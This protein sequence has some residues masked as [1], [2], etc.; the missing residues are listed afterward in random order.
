MSELLIPVRVDLGDSPNKLKIVEGSLRGMA[1]G[2]DEFASSAKKASDGLKQGFTGDAT[3]TIKQQFREANIELQNLVAKFGALSPQAQAAAA[4]VANLRDVIEDS[5]RAAQSA[6]FEDR[7]RTGAQAIGGVTSAFQI[8]LSVQGLFGEQSKATEEALKKV[9]AAMALTQGI[10]GLT[11]GYKAFQA[12]GASASAALKGIKTGIAATGIGVLLLAVGALVAYWDN[13]KMA[14]SGVS[15]ETKKLQKTQS[16]SLKIEQLKTDLINGQDETLKAQG[17]SEKEILQL[18]SKQII[19]QIE[20]QAAQLRT[21]LLVRKGQVEAAERNARLLK[22][23]LDIITIPTSFLATI[24]DTITLALNKIGV[25]SDDTFKSIGNLRD[26]ATSLV[27]GFLFDPKKEQEA[28]TAATIEDTKALNNLVNQYNGFQNKIKDID[29]KAAKESA[30]KAKERA[31][32]RKEIEKK[33]AE[34]ITEINRLGYS[35]SFQEILKIQDD[36]KQKRKDLAAAGI[37]DFTAINQAERDAILA[38]ETKANA[39]FLKARQSFETAL[40]NVF[41]GGVQKR[42]ASQKQLTDL[43]QRAE[44]SGIKDEYQRKIKEIDNAER[45]EIETL[46]NNFNVKL[47]DLDEYY[48]KEAA[49]RAFYANQ[50]KSETEKKEQ[51]EIAKLKEFQNTLAEAIAGAA[52]SFGEALVSGSNPFLAAFSSIAQSLGSYLQKL[53]KEAILA[54][55]LF[56]KL[57][58]AIFTPAGI[59]IGIA[60]VA[61]GAVIKNLFKKSEKGFATGGYVSGPG[62]EKS[63]SIPARLSNG[64][65]VIS[66]KSVRKYGRQTFDS[67]NRGTAPKEL[68]MFTKSFSRAIVN[69]SESQLADSL[70]ALQFKAGGYVQ[71]FADGGFVQANTTSFGRNG[72]SATALVNRFDVPQIPNVTVNETFQREVPY[73]ATTRISGQDLKLV[74]E[75]AD[76]RFQNAT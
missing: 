14:I 44:V 45:A 69:R 72:A 26:K 39:D 18:K 65:Y 57:Q 29:D 58:G 7:F 23:F 36:F 33:A 73:I 52:E 35:K 40:F 20:I 4:R 63:D 66:A 71:G 27:T 24:V 8:A 43:R 74:L 64:E 10:Q 6:D 25:I 2:A 37:T 30:D 42:I 56:T 62:S 49:I 15:D 41:I 54:S 51:E 60:L 9:Q 50:R 38:V 11:E 32:E 12:L 53:G 17:R 1:K 70:S 28:A 47:D 19:A 13:I 55:K 31:E 3:K 21:N 48:Q 46:Q 76:R 61:L 75:R 67:L 34:I 16:D 68:L 59:G 22:G 5:A